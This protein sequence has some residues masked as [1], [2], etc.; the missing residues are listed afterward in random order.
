MGFDKHM[1][2]RRRLARERLEIYLVHLILRS[3]PVIMIAGLLL[4]MYAVV[5][6][7]VNPIAGV[8]V[9]VPAIHLLLLS[10]S[11]PIV[12]YTSRFI[13]WLATLREDDNGISG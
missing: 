8:P 1:S 12:L 11:F 6:L 2:N 10:N 5:T 13:A 3:R 9:L 4:M 7:F